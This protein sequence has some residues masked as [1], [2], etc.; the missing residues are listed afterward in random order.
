MKKS[1]LLLSLAFILILWSCQHPGPSVN[2]AEYTSFISG[3]TSGIISKKDVVRIKL[4]K[5]AMLGEPGKE[6]PGQL[7]RF[8]PPVKGKNYLITEDLIEFRPDSPWPSGKE[9]RASFDLGKVLDVPENLQSFTFMFR[10]IA[11]SFT[12]NTGR[13]ISFGERE[14]KMKRIEGSLNSADYLETEDLEKLMKISSS[15]GDFKISW[16]AGD[17]QN[18]FNFMIDSIPRLDD[19]YQLNLAWKGSPL[20]I[21]VEGSYTYDIPSIHDFI[22]TGYS[23]NQGEEQSIDIEL[24]DPV[25]PDQD[26]TGLVYLREGDACRIVKDQNIIHLYPNVRITGERTL[27]IENS[28]RNDM[29]D[30]LKAR[31]EEPVLFEDLKPAVEFLTKGV[32]MPDPNGLYLPV[33]A[34]SLRAVDVIVYKI[35][36]NNIPYFLQ[37]NNFD[38]RYFYNFVSFGRPVYARTIMLDEDPSIDLKKWNN[39]SLDL[40]PLMKEDPGAVYRVSLSFRKAYSVYECEKDTKEDISRYILTDKSLED[41]IEKWDNQQGYYYE[42]PDDYEYYYRNDPCSNS[43]YIRDYFSEKMVLSSQVGVTAKSSDGRNYNLV[44]TDLVTAEPLSGIKVEFYNYQNQPLGS[45]STGSDGQADIQLPGQPYYLKASKDRQRTWL[46]LDDGSALS[47][48]QFDVGG[49]VVQKGLKGMIY[50]DRGVWRPGDTVFLTFILDDRANPLPENHPVNLEVFNSRSQ[51]AYST[52]RTRGT[53]GFYAFPVPTGDDAPS[54][55]WTAVVKVGGATFQK[56][57]RIETIK[58]NRLK[59]KLDFNQPVLNEFAGKPV[60]T[61]EVKWLFGAVA[62]GVKTVVNMSFRKTKTAFSGYEKYTFE[63]P[64]SYWW[65]NESNVYNKEVD[66]L[67]QGRFTLDLPYSG[68]APGMMDAIFLVRAYEKGGDYST[69]VFTKQYSPFQRYVGINVPD[70]G[71]YNNMLETDKDHKVEI[72][73]VDWQGRPVSVKE[74]WVKVYRVQWRWWWSS[75][76]EDLAYYIGSN[77]AEVVQDLTISTTDGK[78]SFNLRVNYPAWGRYLIIVRDPNG[79]QA[80]LPVYLDWPSY[81]DRSGRANPAGA[82]MLTFSADKDKYKVGDK[83]VISFPATPNSRALVS[84]ESGS[85]ILSSEWKMCN[86]AEE[87]FT[88]DI[89]KGMAPNVYVY[90]SLIQPHKQT[91]NDLPIRMYGVIPLMVEDQETILQPVISMAPE[92]EPEKDFTVKVSEKSGKPMTFTIAVVDE[93]LLDLTRFKTPDPYSIFYA[94]EALGIKTWDMYDLVMGAF[95]GRLQK[96]LAIGGDEEA[97]LAK[98]KK[99]QRFVPVVRFEGPFTLQKGEKKDITMHMPNYVGSVRTM[100][101]AGKDGAY[102]SA[103]NTTP[104]RKALM[105]LATLPRVLGTGEEVELPVSV[106]AMNDKVKNVKVEVSGNDLVSLSSS[107]QNISFAQIGEQMAYFSL[108][109]GEKTGIAKIRVTATSGNESAFH[110]IEIEVRNPNPMITRTADYV[111]EPGQTLPVTYE[112]FGTTG[113]N[114]GQVTFSSLPDFDLEK[115]LLYLIHYPYGCIEQTTSS[116]FPQ[117]FLSSL[118]DLSSDQKSR[119]D[120]NVRAT[121][122]RIANFQRSDGS[123][124]YWPGQPGYSDWGT[125]YAGHFLLMAENKGYLLP[126]GMKDSWLAFQQKTAMSYRN[127]EGKGEWQSDLCQAYRLYTLALAQKPSLAAMNRMR[128]AGNL[129]PSSAW[130]LAAA[131][132]YAGKPEV[133]EELISGKEIGITNLYEYPGIT[134]GS[135][136]RDM[137][138]TLEVLTMLKRDADAFRLLQKMAGELRNGYSSTQTTAFCLY[139]ISRYAGEKGGEGLDV[140]YTVNG[141]RQTVNTVKAVTTADLKETVGLKGTVSVTNKKSGAKLFVSVTLSGQPLQGMETESSSNLN[142]SVTYEDDAGNPVDISSLKQGTDFIAKVTVQHTGKMFPVANL[143]LSQI[144]PSGWEIVNTRVQDVAS[145]LKEDGYDYRDYRDDRVFTFFGLDQFQKKTF[146]VRLNAA[147]AGNYYLPAVTCGAMYESNI[148]ANTKGRWVRVVR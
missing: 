45:I 35:F 96:V 92:L 90:L 119:I 113:T 107:S 120:R 23:V 62:P 127:N 129:S 34:V 84:I 50:G 7:F 112:F 53:D 16:E 18:R 58:P 88:I 106:F 41:L 63:N 33:K 19:A 87:T 36:E 24:S 3:Y 26:L 28:V 91:V 83:A 44:T 117:L 79:H 27:I 29:R 17:G 93:G 114:T 65:E 128:E 86:Q 51:L 110:E 4:N 139:A 20:G 39:F 43:Y 141:D 125:S 116:A 9:I 2:P 118:A 15:K 104:V 61:I 134:Y 82:T 32:I 77:D 70:G 47:L 101:I 64:A 85:H 142:M 67:G 71:S 59:I 136:L 5:P 21:D 38:S 144:F 80:G 123:F 97:M 140:E 10:T 76:D 30:N 89:T 69:D 1:A 74:L 56:P 72:A 133:A 130:V 131:Y 102:G 13:M 95:G 115:N 122:N 111:V 37:D 46:R 55:L 66:N 143:A 109:T 60:G 6:I 22:F 68:G 81:V 40:S 99:A 105:V 146:R 25:D 42:W 148:Q 8:D 147:Y 14:H 145:G 49:D 135:D 103:Q 75:G 124:T 94:R 54:G 57:L 78:G 98:N 121:I 100:V 31:V 137:A 48:S 132:L 126:A 138:F 11:P 108:K 73:T 52:T 12:V